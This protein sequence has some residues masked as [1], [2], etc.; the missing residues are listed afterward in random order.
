[1]A[2][3]TTQPNG[4]RTVQFVGLDGCR[5]S[6]RLGKVG[7][8]VAESVKLRIERLLA[9]KLTGEPVDPETSLWLQRIDDA[10]AER[11]SRVGLIEPR[12]SAALGDMVDRYIERRTDLKPK[13]RKILRN[14][15]DRLVDY[16]GSDRLIRDIT[17]A[18]AQDWRRWMLGQGLSEATTRTYSRGAKQIFKDAVQR[19][20]LAENPF[21]ALPAGSIANQNDRIVTIE[22]IEKVLAACPSQ[23]WRMLIALCRFGGLRC[24]SETHLLRWQDVDLDRGRMRVR[25]PKTEHHIGHES[26]VVP[27]QPAL[28][29]EFVRT[30]ELD[31][32]STTVITLTRHNLHKRM[33]RFIARSGVEPWAD[34]FH[35]LRRSCETEWA[36]QFPE[37]AVVKWIGNSV[38][39]A[40]KH[41][42]KVTDSLMERVSA[43]ER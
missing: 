19:K 7:K 11:L 38:V 14:A 15:G 35:C 39:V 31:D 4:R 16:F 26:R 25:S 17:V 9:A 40:R 18:D 24:P 30:Q 42:L 10:F 13:S 23:Q 41:Y 8:A 21:A 36:E 37:F 12:E 34:P 5:R 2:S 1:M 27:I 22:E 29:R 28:L 6:I 20:V 3:I 33:A 43:R 32:D